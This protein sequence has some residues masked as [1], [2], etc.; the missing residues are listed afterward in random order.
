MGSRLTRVGVDVL[1]TDGRGRWMLG[2]PD[3]L[4]VTG[5]P[6]DARP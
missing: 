5:F 3:D 2:F 4:G 1:V 6:I